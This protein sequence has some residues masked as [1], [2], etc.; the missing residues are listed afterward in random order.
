M[1]R[2][3]K[4]EVIGGFERDTHTESSNQDRFRRSA[5]AAQTQPLH[6]ANRQGQ[7]Y[8]QNPH[9]LLVEDGVSKTTLDRHRGLTAKHG[10]QQHT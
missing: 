10:K 5:L 3:D 4:K 6:R 8:L 2:T 7:N 9:V 1:I